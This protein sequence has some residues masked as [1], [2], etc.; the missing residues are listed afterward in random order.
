MLYE[1][2]FEYFATFSEKDSKGLREMFS[3]DVV[4]R[5]WDILAN[6]IDEVVQANEDT[7]DSVETIKITPIEIHESPNTIVGEIEI[8]VNGEETLLVTDVIVFDEN[9]KIKEVRA[10][11][12]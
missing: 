9:E 6:G 1:K 4:L 8:D 12:G 5:D 10:Y 11:K 2:A 7:F 3:E